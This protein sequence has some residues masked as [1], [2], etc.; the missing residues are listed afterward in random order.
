MKPIQDILPD[1]LAR[2][3]QARLAYRQ[4]QIA[5][6]GW[7][8]DV[9]CAECGDTGYLP[10]RVGI[11]CLSC[12]EGR[13][14]AE[15][16]HR[17]EAWTTICP[18]RFRD[19]Q[20]ETHPNRAAVGAVQ[21]W[22]ADDVH[23]GTNLLLSGP[24]GTG[25][26]SLAYAALREAFVD[27]RT[28]KAGS[29]PDL[30]DANRPVDAGRERD[31]EAQVTNLQRVQ[32]LLLD[33]LGAEKP[34][35]W[36]REQLYRIVNGRYERG[37]P[38]IITTNQHDLEERVGGATLSRFREDVRTVAVVGADLRRAARFRIVE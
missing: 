13:A 10:D 30:M 7:N 35:D 38:T 17:E 29:V 33:D 23:H 36:Q 19:A 15:R 12:D 20:F 18:R 34:S 27:G 11:A 32:V 6:H 14:I 3:R 21:T 16:Q 9:S 37:L 1:Q 22:C 25:K 26:T 31:S 2:I 5:R 24:L 8:A 28:V 4:Q